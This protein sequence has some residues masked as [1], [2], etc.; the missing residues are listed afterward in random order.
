MRARGA[1]GFEAREDAFL[2]DALA[3]DPDQLRLLAVDRER[4][5]R[6]ALALNS[7]HLLHDLEEVTQVVVLAHRVALASL[8]AP[9][10]SSPL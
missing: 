10:R 2:F 7:R 3:E 4:D 8:E 5:P 9:E 1:V 6:A